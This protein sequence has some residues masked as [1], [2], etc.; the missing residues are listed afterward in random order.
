MITDRTDY[1]FNI[2]PEN[3]NLFKWCELINT[4]MSDDSE[5]KF[6][7]NSSIQIIMYGSPIIQ[8]NP[9][10]DEIGYLASWLDDSVNN[11]IHNKL[12][13]ITFRG[14]WQGIDNGSMRET[15]IRLKYVAY[16]VYHDLVKKY[17]Y[18]SS[19][20]LLVEVLEDLSIVVPLTSRKEMV[21]FRAGLERILFQDD[22]KEW[23]I[24]PVATQL[25]LVATRLV[26]RE[27][28]PQVSTFGF[29]TTQGDGKLLY[30]V[31][32]QRIDPIF[33]DDINSL[34]EKYTQEFGFELNYYLEN[35]PITDPEKSDDVTVKYIDRNAFLRSYDT[36]SSDKSV[37]PK[38]LSR[39]VFYPEG[40]MGLFGIDLFA[41]NTPK[42]IL[43]KGLYKNPPSQKLVSI[44]FGRVVVEGFLPAD[45]FRNEWVMTV[46]VKLHEDK[47][48]KPQLSRELKPKQFRIIPLFDLSYRRLN[49]N[50][51]G[52][53]EVVDYSSKDVKFSPTEIQKL[54]KQEQDF[55]KQIENITNWL[56]KRGR[57]ISSWGKAV[58]N[59]REISVETE[60]EPR[61]LIEIND[62]L[63]DGYQEPDSG[64]RAVDY[65]NQMVKSS[66]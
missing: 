14:A 8:A 52:R 10:A 58:I 26:V 19:N 55:A 57:F 56:W 29:G 33:L 32:N 43:L 31:A 40:L 35:V 22:Y 37:T 42:E 15:L 20:V 36:I 63:K 61:G 59:D 16:I 27:K 46:N 4:C 23:S 62:I 9:Q 2:T 38:T 13:M 41:K 25:E 12:P 64:E 60:I 6:P 24:F 50:S 45:T 53:T 49:T 48:F 65:L 39:I 17:K 47:S 7:K 5:N 66:S 11:I 18:L 3:K 28:F 30:V 54:S 34:S 44:D 1:I 21:E 51:Q